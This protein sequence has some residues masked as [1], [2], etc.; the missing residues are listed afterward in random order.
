MAEF[1]EAHIE[2]L[3]VFLPDFELVVEAST[4]LSGLSGYMSIFTFTN[5]KYVWR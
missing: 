2:N 3:S 5:D 4:T 1:K